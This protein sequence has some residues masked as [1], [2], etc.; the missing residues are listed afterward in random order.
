VI[1]RLLPRRLARNAGFILFGR[2][3]FI[4]IWFVVTPRILHTLGPERFGVWGLLFLL[5]GYL[6]TFDLGLG[7]TVVKFTAEHAAGA[8]WDRL[9][10]TLGEITRVY[11]ILGV[12]WV[13][14]LVALHPLLMR[15]LHITPEY[16]AEVRF[17]LLASSA[18]FAFANL[19]GVGTGILNGLQRMDL[20]NGILVLSSMPQVGLLL[21]GL[22]RGMGLYAVVISTAAGWLVTAVATWVALRGV[23]PQLRWPS[24]ASRGEGAP[25]FRFSTLMQLNNV[26]QLSQHQIDKLVLGF[27][28]GVSSVGDFELGFR[29]ANAV[30]SLPVLALSPLLPAFTEM[31]AASHSQPFRDLC[32]RGTR[33]LA[34]FSLLLAAC[35]IPAAPLVIRA[36]V[37]PDHRVAEGLAQWMLGAFALNLCTNVASTAVRAA[38]QP[39]R[40]VA[41]AVSALVLHVAVSVVFI[42]L[43][44]APGVGPAMLLAMIVWWV[45]FLA[46]FARW[47]DRPV[48]AILVDPF[49][50]PIICFLPAL[51]VGLAAVAAVESRFTLGR[52]PALLLAAGAGAAAAATFALAWRLLSGPR[53]AVQVPGRNAA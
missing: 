45:F 40:E 22:A 26:L 39:E 38:G 12:V 48:S 18:V 17:A 35:S 36:W 50:R 24:V 21:W 29:V 6:A 42:R 52:W 33:S 51:G 49:Q 34:M 43:W 11:L 37:G 23:A 25:W 30:Q 7:T 3:W 32:L 47:I 41:P 1:G 9:H 8:D 27:L 10:S 19:V 15:G 31:G 46:R 53:G 5:S 2:L 14:A 4:L 13:A 16:W 44:G 28:L 20:A